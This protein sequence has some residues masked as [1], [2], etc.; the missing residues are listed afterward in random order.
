LTIDDKNRLLIPAQFRKKIVPEVHGSALFVTLKKMPDF[1][2][3]PW[4][5]SEDFFR[6]LVDQ[7]APAVLTPNKKQ[8][9]YTHR[10]ISIADEIEW[11]G[12]GRVVL[13][14][15]ILGPAEL[16]GDRGREVTLIGAKDHFELWHRSRWQAYRAILIDESDEIW[17]SAE[18]T[19]EQAA[20]KAAAEKPATQQA[21]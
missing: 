19:E 3:V 15:K 6:R 16:G 2:F 4:F 11:D 17:D 10:M 18:E 20:G 21:S 9:K 1:G 14:P 12:Q 8:L 13:P 7:H 5:Y